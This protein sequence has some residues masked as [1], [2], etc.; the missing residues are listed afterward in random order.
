[1]GLRGWR[2]PLNPTCRP[3]P[4]DRFGAPCCNRWQSDNRVRATRKRLIP[5][6]LF[7]PSKLGFVG[8]S[9]DW[10]DGDQTLVRHLVDSRL[11]APLTEEPGGPR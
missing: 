9:R 6:Q 2:M 3:A 11:S 1:V 7:V 4:M 10:S 5:A 8:A